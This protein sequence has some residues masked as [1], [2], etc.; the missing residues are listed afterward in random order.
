[1]K[2]KEE[3]GLVWSSINNILA[4]NG[5]GFQRRR[6]KERPREYRLI[7]KQQSTQAC[8]MEFK[9]LYRHLHP[10]TNTRPHLTHDSLNKNQTKKQKNSQR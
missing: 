7:S 4:L 5:F 3:E 6:C 2:S 1:M 9:E 10:T 8:E